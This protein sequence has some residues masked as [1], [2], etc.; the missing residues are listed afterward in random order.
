MLTDVSCESVAYIQYDSEV[1]F[2]KN[3]DKKDSVEENELGLHREFHD[4]EGT[5]CSSWDCTG[6]IPTPPQSEAEEESYEELY[7]FLPDSFS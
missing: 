7:P 5:V 6:L 1:I 4:L 2:I 3:N